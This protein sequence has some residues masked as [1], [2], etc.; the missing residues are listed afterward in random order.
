MNRRCNEVQKLSIDRNVMGRIL[1]DAGTR[2]N[3]GAARC[4][5]SSRDSAANNAIV[6]RQTVPS[7]SE[8]AAAVNHD[9]S[10]PGPAHRFALAH[11]SVPELRLRSFRH[12][13]LA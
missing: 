3:W 12:S 1:P 4:Q 8:W 10:N 5:R 7:L 2:A 9:Q 6:E 11:S 13:Y